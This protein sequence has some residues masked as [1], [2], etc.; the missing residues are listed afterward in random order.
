MS[1]KRVGFFRELPHGD[2]EG[3]SLLGYV[4]KGDSREQAALAD[5]L[6]N[7]ATLAVAPQ[8]VRDVLDEAEDDIGSLA[9]MTDGTWIWPADLA[10]YVQKYNVSLPVEF[11]EHARSL[12]WNPPEL[13]S[14]E[15][16]AVEQAMFE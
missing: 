8:R 12:Q 16:L 2:S 14:G 5:Y 10:Y 15:L 1:I 3:E 9:I 13:N 11:V 6:A 7:G 4:S